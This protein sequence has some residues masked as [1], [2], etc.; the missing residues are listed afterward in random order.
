MLAFLGVAV[1]PF[2]K[3]EKN[4]RVMTPAPLTETTVFH[5]LLV[6]DCALTEAQFRAVAFTVPPPDTIRPPVEST[7]R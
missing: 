2:C 5:V 4:K 1:L 3:T 6:N 7:L